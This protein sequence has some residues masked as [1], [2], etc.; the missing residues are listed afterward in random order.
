MKTMARLFPALFLITGVLMLGA[1]ERDSKFVTSDWLSANLDNPN[2]RIID[3]RGDI[4][5]YWEAHIPGA[6]FLD[7]ETLRWPD[8]GVPGKLAPA[9]TL[10]R[11]LGEMGIG[12]NMKVVVYSEVNHYRAAYF[13][14]ALDYLKHKSWAVLENGF[15]GWKRQALGTTQDF[16]RIKPVRY[17]FKGDVD[18]EIRA[19]T[20]EI[21]DRD[22]GKTV[23]LDVRPA[24]LY[25]GEKG[26][27]KRR[28]HI[29]GAINHLWVQDLNNNGTWK[30]KEILRKA[31]AELGVVPEKLIY[32][33][34]GQGQMAS[35]T[36]LTLK[37]VLGFPRVKNYDGSY[38]EWSNL[39]ALPVETK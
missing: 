9:D 30:D 31:Y 20:E 13:V 39:D 35:H 17:E 21:K 25:S 19:T 33:S 6:V 10:A 23:L 11:L 12:R 15:V 16:P 36:Y 28:G 22:L 2:V 14:W 7:S 27:W 8:M 4:R 18:R 32:V 5:D 34:C 26:S 24:E 38:N 1:Q 29:P 37:Y 3:M